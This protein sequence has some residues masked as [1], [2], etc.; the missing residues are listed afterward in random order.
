MTIKHR[1]KAFIFKKKERAEADQ[2]FSV[3]TEDFGKLEIVARAIR[4]TKSKLRAGIDVFYLSEIEFI[5]GK[6]NKTLTDAVKI[7]KFSNINDDINKF[8]AAHR[9]AD[10][11]EGFIKGQEKDK[12]TFD[13]LN[14]FFENLNYRTHKNKN[15]QLIF[16]YFFWNCASIQG[17]KLEI[18]KC[19][20]CQKKINP[21]SIYFSAKAGGIMCSN[22]FQQKRV[23]AELCFKINEDVI[24]V[25]RLIF[26][27]NWN[28]ISRLKV[29][30]YSQDLLNK[31]YENSILSFYPQHC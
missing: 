4:K 8:E 27:K 31:I 17:Y 5:Q 2:V 18:E 19:A 9:V 22:C 13:L 24:K 12:K 26:A 29:D 3:F 11:L 1:T 10:T 20:T 25:L 14:E 16:Y 23:V 6:N 21:D 7:K 28:I 30:E 15:R